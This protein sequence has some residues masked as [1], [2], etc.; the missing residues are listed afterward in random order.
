ML[1]LESIKFQRLGWSL[2][3]MTFLDRI[4]KQAITKSLDEATMAF[5]GIFQRDVSM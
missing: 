3:D 5:V 1:T 2:L 4:F